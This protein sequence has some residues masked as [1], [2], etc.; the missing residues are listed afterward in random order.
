MPRPL[1]PLRRLVTIA[2]AVLFD[3]S[4]SAL[5]RVRGQMLNRCILAD[6]SVHLLSQPADA[7]LPLSEDIINLANG[8]H[9]SR[10]SI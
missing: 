6:S 7:V 3:Y 2:A 4:V 1:K 10:M 9:L 5:A 8:R